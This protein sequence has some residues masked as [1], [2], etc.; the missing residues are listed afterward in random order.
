MPRP[1][2]RTSA[3]PREASPSLLHLARVA[4]LFVARK[5][6]VQGL[7]V[8]L[9]LLGDGLVLELRRLHITLESIMSTYNK[10]CSVFWELAG[11]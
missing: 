8:L 2:P 7:D 4:L 3:V 5:P 11:V 10:N 6:V 1:F 9:A